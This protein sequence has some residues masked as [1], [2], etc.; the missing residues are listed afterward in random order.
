MSHLLEAPQLYRL[1]SKYITDVNLRT[2]IVFRAKRTLKFDKREETGQKSSATVQCC[3]WDQCYLV[4]AAKL[5]RKLEAISFPVLYSGKI[6]LGDL[7][8]VRLKARTTVTKAPR[9]LNGIQSLGLYKKALRE[10][11]SVNDL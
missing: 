3:G 2:K 9:F 6:A 4:G 11:R 8:K 7:E 5:L 1:L 10:I